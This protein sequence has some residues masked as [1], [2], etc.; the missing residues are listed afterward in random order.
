FTPANQSQIALLC[1]SRQSLQLGVHVA[2][3]QDAIPQP[4]TIEP[5][6]ILPLSMRADL[7]RIAEQRRP[8]DV[9]A[10]AA[11]RSF[12][13]YS[14]HRSPPFV[15]AAP[16]RTAETFSLTQRASGNIV[17]EWNVGSWS[18]RLGL[19]LKPRR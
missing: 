3:F 12:V 10:R 13:L 16:L 5:D 17:E 15:Q 1:Q 7:E 9:D 2:L 4:A 19:W 18:M 8:A 14:N 11:I 6:N